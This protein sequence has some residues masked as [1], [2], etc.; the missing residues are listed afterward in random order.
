MGEKVNLTVE[1]RKVLGKKVAQLRR[2]GMVPGVVYG[3]GIEATAVMAPEGVLNKVWREVGGRQPVHLVIGEGQRRLAMIKS[4]EFEPLQRKLRHISF[5][6]VKQN[7]K[8]E[9]EVPIRIL[10]EGE[11]VAQQHGLIVLQTLENVQISALPADLPDAVE[12]PSDKLVEEGD[13]VTVADIVAIPGVEI[14]NDPE[15]IVANVYSPAALEAQNA[16]AAGDAEEAVPA[17][18]GEEAVA[19]GEAGAKTEGGDETAEGEKTDEGK[20]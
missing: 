12:V 8:V 11:T 16:E 5:H 17:E 10:G 3:D 15:V 14:H 2:E 20:K 9:T 4:A 19:Q 18:E 13:T 6:V 1:E 7:E